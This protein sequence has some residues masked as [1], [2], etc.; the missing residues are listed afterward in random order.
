MY[1]M[2]YIFDTDLVA[3]LTHFVIKGFCRCGGRISREVSLSC[4]LDPIQQSM[5]QAL[6]FL[7]NED[8][9]LLRQ[10]TNHIYQL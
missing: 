5:K 3:D 8:L 1:P 2:M 6:H 7:N 9:I 4:V 10:E